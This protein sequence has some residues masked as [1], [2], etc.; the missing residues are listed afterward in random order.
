MT[1]RTT[2][3]VMSSPATCRCGTTYQVEFPAGLPAGDN[4]QTVQC[5]CGMR[6]HFHMHV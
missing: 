6:I 1:R 3:P 4:V 2:T 5:P